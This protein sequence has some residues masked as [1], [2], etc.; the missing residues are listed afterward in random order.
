MKT[1]QVGNVILVIPKK[2]QRSLEIDI[3]QSLIYVSWI[4]WVTPLNLNIN[5][6][7]SK[8]C[9]KKAFE[10][11]IFLFHMEY[12]GNNKTFPLLHHT[13]NSK[14]FF[15]HRGLVGLRLF[16]FFFH[17]ISSS[18]YLSVILSKN[19]SII[20]SFH[21]LAVVILY[22]STGTTWKYR[23]EPYGSTNRITRNRMFRWI[24]IDSCSDRHSL[25]IPYA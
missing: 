5:L 1:L 20:A 18:V 13:V 7:D 2:I 9:W 6:E 12:G 3:A 8:F 25:H 4:Q 21:A 17:R 10:V 22:Y 23:I 11:N 19:F 15:D 14:L 16:P 24:S